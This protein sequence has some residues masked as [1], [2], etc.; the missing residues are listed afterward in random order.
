MILSCD[1]L[2]HLAP[3]VNSLRIHSA[4]LPDCRMTR[5]GH[6]SNHAT[7]RSEVSET[8]NNKF[9]P[10]IERIMCRVWQEDNSGCWIWL[11]SS[12]DFNRKKSNP[13]PVMRHNGKPQQLVYRLTFELLKGKITGGLWVLHRCDNSLCVNPYHLFLGTN[14][15]NMKDCA[16]KGRHP[17]LNNPTVQAERARQLGLRNTWSSY[18]RP[19]RKRP[20]KRQHL[21]ALIA[22]ANLAAVRGESESSF[23]FTTPEGEHVYSTR[24]EMAVVS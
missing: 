18:K 17:L 10:L 16:A 11:G 15:D 4:I 5:R 22:L 9:L 19:N 2:N 1:S 7:M 21:A 6:F 14:S 23:M 20:M 24:K 3:A 8:A 13:R 12:S